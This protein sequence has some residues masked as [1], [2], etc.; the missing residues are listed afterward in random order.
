M[1]NLWDKPYE[2]DAQAKTGDPL[3]VDPKAD[4]PEGYKLRSTSAARGQGMLLYENPVD[5]WNGQ[6]PYRLRPTL[7][8]QQ[9]REEKDMQLCDRE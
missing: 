7:E 4:S 9:V 6:R 5:F 1:N 3:F 8:G 2:R